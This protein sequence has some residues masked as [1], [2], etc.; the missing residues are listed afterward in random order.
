MSLKFDTNKL[1]GRIIEKFNSQ[2]AFCKKINMKK[3]TLCRKLN[4]LA[5]F[6]SEEIYLISKTLEISDSE[7]NAYF[8]TPNV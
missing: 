8:F 6:S 2:S 1:R 5:K 7:I 3:G 4:G